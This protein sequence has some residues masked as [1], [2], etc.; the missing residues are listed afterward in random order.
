MFFKGFGGVLVFQGWA[1]FSCVGRFSNL[2]V[3]N[4]FLDFLL[5]AFFR[6]RLFY[7]CWAEISDVSVLGD[8]NAHTQGPGRSLNP[9]PYPKPKP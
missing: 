4:V 6:K 5:G 9:K 3:H 7:L 8:N 2:L 1:E